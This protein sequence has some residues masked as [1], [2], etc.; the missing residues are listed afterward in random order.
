MLGV[1]TQLNKGYL[2]IEGFYIYF[3]LVLYWF[4]SPQPHFGAWRLPGGWRTAVCGNSLTHPQVFQQQLHHLVAE[5]QDAGLQRTAQVSHQ[6]HCCQA[7]L[8]RSKEMISQ[9]KRLPAGRGK[10]LF[11]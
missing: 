5:G 4:S 2:W 3:S 1:Y 11:T 6:A 10:A 9:Q 7:N 8:Q